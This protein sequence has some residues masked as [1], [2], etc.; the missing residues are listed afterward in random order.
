LQVL[1]DVQMRKD[2]LPM[3]GCTAAQKAWQCMDD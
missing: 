2:K 3:S 1:R